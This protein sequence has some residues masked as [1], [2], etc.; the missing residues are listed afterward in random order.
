MKHASSKE[1][2]PTQEARK[3]ELTDVAIRNAKAED[4]QQKLSDKKGLFVL[5][6]PNGS[7]YWR[8]KYRYSGK[9]KLL[10][11]GIYPD[12]SLKKARERRDEARKQLS[13]GADPGNIKK[14]TKQLIRDAIENSFEPIAREWF[15]KCSPNW[16]SG[17]SKRIMRLLERDIFP[18]LGNNPIA[19]ITA[20][21][22]LTVI[23][24]IEHRGAL[25]TAHRALGN[26][27]TI[28]R[29]AI[30]TQR[31]ERDPSFDLRGALPPVKSE[32]FATITDPK[33]IGQLLR[34][35]RSYKGTYITRTALKIAPM[36][37]IRP[38]ELRKA[39]CSGFDFDN[40]EWRIPKNRMKK[41]RVHIVPLP[42]Q[43]IEILKELHSLTGN[44]RYI[45]PGVRSKDRPM[46]ENTVLAAIRRLG[47]EKGQMTGH[48]FRHMASTILNERGWNKDAIERQLSHVD[49]NQIR[50]RYNYAQYLDERKK[51]MQ[52]WADYLQSLE[53]SPNLTPIFRKAT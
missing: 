25:E 35:L 43:A 33:E 8:I 39:E 40:S 26:C 16:S 17:H 38:G 53:E 5:I 14:Q 32:S 51:M 22:L 2:T 47:Y 36:L 20:T 37:F 4:K 12:V 3:T 48:G 19:E 1:S 42:R 24:R 10:S 49:G 28:F 27:G 13:N 21:E 41:L 31:V 50:D 52:H 45:F 15:E 18:W 6:H 46:S 23:R 34:V 9:E 7:K 29:Y 30:S 44:G 11:L